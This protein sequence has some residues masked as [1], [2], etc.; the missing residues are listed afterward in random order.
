MSIYLTVGAAPPTSRS[1][2]SCIGPGKFI[3]GKFLGIPFTA[4]SWEM[5]NTV[6]S[7]EDQR[8]SVV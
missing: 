5:A 2:F 7:H 4:H 1:A 6:S 8:S 3:P